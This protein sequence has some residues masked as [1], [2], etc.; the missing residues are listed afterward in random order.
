V[1]ANSQF[2]ID[3][4]IP[5]PNEGREKYPWSKMQ[6]GDSFFVP[7]GRQTTADKRPGLMVQITVPAAAKRV[8]GTKWAV[9][10]ATENGVN[11]VRV[12]R[13]L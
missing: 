11:G 5:V 1:D 9:R 6:P 10:Q 8:P 3:K 7:G 12:W 13:V 2:Q 4:N